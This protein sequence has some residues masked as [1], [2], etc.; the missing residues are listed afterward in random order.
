MTAEMQPQLQE[1]MFEGS[2]ITLIIV[3]CIL[4]GRCQTHACTGYLRTDTVWSCRASMTV[5]LLN[6]QLVL[7]IAL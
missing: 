7:L 6:V 4:T 1:C 3:Y 2:T 5:I